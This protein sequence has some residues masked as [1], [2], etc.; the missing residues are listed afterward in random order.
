[1]RGSQL[2]FDVTSLFIRSRSYSVRWKKIEFRLIDMA[3]V[4]SGRIRGLWTSSVR[5]VWVPL[6]SLTYDAT[7]AA[8][9]MLGRQRDTETSRKKPRSCKRHLKSTTDHVLSSWNISLVTL[10]CH[11]DFLTRQMIVYDIIRGWFRFGEW[12]RVVTKVGWQPGLHSGLWGVVSL[13]I[14]W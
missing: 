2:I 11:R 9:A 6:N 3:Y 8:K 13:G 5:N 12:W 7:S 4:S 1:M 14:R 10:W